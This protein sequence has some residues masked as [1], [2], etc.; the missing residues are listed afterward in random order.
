M[1]EYSDTSQGRQ[2][3]YSVMLRNFCIDLYLLKILRLAAPHNILFHPAQLTDELFI[4]LLPRV[5]C[6][7]QRGWSTAKWS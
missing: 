7:G 5:G 4:P 1:R 2:P 6:S 3:V